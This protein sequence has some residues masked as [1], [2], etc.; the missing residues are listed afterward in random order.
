VGGDD[1]IDSDA[2]Q[3]TGRTDP[4]T[5]AIGETKTDIDAGV[6]DPR[7]GAIGDRVWIDANGNGQQDLGEDG[8][9]GVTVQ[10]IA[11]GMVI[12]TTT[13]DA[14]G[15]YL[16]DGLG[17]GDYQVRFGGADGFVF[18]TADSGA[19]DSDSDADQTTGETGTISLG[20]GETDLTVDAGLVED[21]DAPTP[22]DDMAKTCVTD[23]VTVDALANDDD[24]DGDALTITAVGGQAIAEGGSVV[25]DGVT[26]SLIGG[27][28]VFDGSAAAALVDLN[29]GEEAT[30]AYSY[31]VSDGTAAAV[32]SIEVTFC[33][34]AETLDELYESL[35]TSASYQLRTDSIALPLDG[36][37]FD[38]RIDGT[39][40]ARFDG[41]T[42]DRAYCLSYLD[43]AAATED[44][45]TAP[46][47]TADILAGTDTSAFSPAQVSI[48]N[49]QT[50][51]N[52][53]DLINWLVAQDFVG[54][55][56]AAV[57]GQ[58]TDWE[59]QRAIW[60]LT[61]G[62]N[63]D[64]LSGI[65]PD[66]GNNADVDYLVGQAIANGEG[67]TQDIGGIVTLIVNPN[68]ATSVNS[69]PFIIAINAADYDC[70]CG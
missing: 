41:V 23:A 55:N 32:A 50:A 8:K 29:V 65:S 1:T 62:V 25:I 44:F 56:G 5:L 11:G 58:F 20:L 60:E 70:L 68:P 47:N 27:K 3:T 14:N 10:L 40:D 51:A 67:F 57:D 36:S 9:S 66:F 18:T 63:T 48:A 13:T 61:D 35:P 19:D 38:I 54:A 22:D 42:F 39:G 26:V 37:A 17:A 59:I 53:L 49:G 69:Q 6:E 12:A 2:D 28:L 30:L 4:V 45:A 24:P 34:S 52:N 15:E 7:T 33:G 31:T 64:F 46:T 21:N 43:P 16:F